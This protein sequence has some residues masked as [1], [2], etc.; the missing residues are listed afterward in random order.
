MSINIQ[1][2]KS[3]IERIVLNISNN[4][5]TEIEKNKENGKISIE[6]LKRVINDYGS[7]IIP[8]PSNAYDIAETYFIEREN[9]I[10]VYMPIWTK[11]EGRSDLTLF[12]SCFEKN[13]TPFVEIN[14]LHVL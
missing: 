12:V 10:D 13:G 11:E 4:N 1:H 7:S 8:L 9:K 14:D 5:F 3:K 2:F 6:D